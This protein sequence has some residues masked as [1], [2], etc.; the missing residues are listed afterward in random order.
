VTLGKS[1]KDKPMTIFFAK[2]FDLMKVALFVAVFVGL[3]GLVLQRMFFRARTY[4]CED[5]GLAFT[6]GAGAFVPFALLAYYFQWRLCVATYAYLILV[7][8]LAIAFV[9]IGKKR[10]FA[11]DH[12]VLT[13]YDGAYFIFIVI[14]IYILRNLSCLSVSFSSDYWYH[15]AQVRY[16]VDG[17]VIKNVF[18]FLP[19]EI[20]QWMYPYNSY[21]L[22]LA[23]AAK[24]TQTDV[25]HTWQALTFVLTVIF[26]SCTLLFFRTLLVRRSTAL[27]AIM[28]F[29]LP[30]L[31]VTMVSGIGGLT[32]IRNICYPKVGSLWI[33]LPALST[34]LLLFVQEKI[35]LAGIITAA[36]IAVG[37]Q[38][39]H[40]ANFMFIGIIAAA[41]FLGF[42]LTWQVN[43]LRRLVIFTIAVII[44]PLALFYFLD[45]RLIDSVKTVFGFDTK[46]LSPDW[47]GASVILEKIRQEGYIT[48]A[49]YF[50]T[51][52]ERSMQP[53]MLMASLVLPLAIIFC[54][55]NKLSRAFLSGFTL[56]PILLAYNPYTVHLMVQYGAPFL[57]RRFLFI[58]PVAHAFAF[59]FLA[60]FD[61]IVSNVRRLSERRWYGL[62]FIILLATMTCF[63][64]VAPLQNKAMFDP[65]PRPDLVILQEQMAEHIPVGSVVLADP[66]LSQVLNGLRWVR[67]ISSTKHLMVAMA[68]HYETRMQDLNTFFSKTASATQRYAIAKKYGAGYVIVRRDLIKEIDIQ[69]FKRVAMSAEYEV[70]TRG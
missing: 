50:Y 15:L 60:L 56:L 14:V 23:A 10:L 41:W 1:S 27:L 11:Y 12:P 51:F 48:K 59:T 36:I 61:L 70:W 31:Y 2:L 63:P 35:G 44:I 22:L 40:V 54:R 62:A 52:G 58:I 64:S 25:I 3:P 42:L 34:C 68:P 55:N 29:F 19:Q 43:Y 47:Y 39:W 33:F 5:L 46:Y 17:G 69:G 4:L 7:I 9:L 66:S 13:R 16:L 6:L 21:Y 26:L 65:H 38:N 45:Y 57:V 49:S 32:V 8:L 37:F 18:P 67:I 53:W 30:F 28:L 24:I 20:P